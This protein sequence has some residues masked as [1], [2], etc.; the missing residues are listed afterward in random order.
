[1][2]GAE[3]DPP[4]ISKLKFQTSHHQATVAARASSCPLFSMK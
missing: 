2:R 1:M 4:L 3:A